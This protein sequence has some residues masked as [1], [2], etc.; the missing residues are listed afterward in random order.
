M[1]RL[2]EAV[3]ASVTFERQLELSS[4]CTRLETEEDGD[5]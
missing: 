5:A 1:V 3:A 4:D 2:G